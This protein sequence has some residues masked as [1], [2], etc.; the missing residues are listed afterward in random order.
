[1]TQMLTAQQL[2]DILRDMYENAK[3]GYAVVL[4]HL[5]GI[6]YAEQIRDSGVTPMDIVRAA[7]INA[8][9]STEIQKGIRLAEF[10]TVKQLV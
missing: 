5:F 2:G 4:I 7:G 3:E 10:V 8:S 9:Y 6:K 1:M